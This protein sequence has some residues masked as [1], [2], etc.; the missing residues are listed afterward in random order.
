MLFNPRYER[1]FIADGQSLADLLAIIRRHPAAF[2]QVYPARCVNNLYLDSPTLSDYYDHI[3]G[4]A[5]RI[6]TRVRWYGLNG[7][8]V[9]KPVLERKLKRGLLG[10]KSSHALPAFSLNASAVRHCL[11]DAIGRAELP[12]LLRFAL[13]HL[14]PALFNRYQRHYFVNA[15]GRFRLTVDSDLEFSAAN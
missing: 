11:A 5:N 6:K 10:G 2:R 14:E 4:V 8:E 12:E 3:N 13:H 7:V 1:K 15:N 9:Q